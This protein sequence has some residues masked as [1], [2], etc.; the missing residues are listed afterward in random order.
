M[1]T[2]SSNTLIIAGIVVLAL[3]ILIFIIRKIR[4]GGSRRPAGSGNSVHEQ[5][6]VGNL[7]YRVNHH[8][9]R[10]FF[11]KFGTVTEARVVKNYRTGRSKGFGFVTF[12]NGAEANHALGAH[13]TDLK[14]RTL[15][16][17]L[18]IP[19]QE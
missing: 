19:R 14:G 18:A 6:Y 7:P 1:D 13:G 9:L 3:L 4:T 5:V 15:V 16:V 11:A 12:S 10:N 8:D 2:I 17:R